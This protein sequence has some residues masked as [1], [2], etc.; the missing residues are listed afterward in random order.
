MGMFRR[1]GNLLRRGK[2]DGDIAAELEAHIELATER[3]MRQG[4]SS[5]DARRE[6]LLRFGNP[7]ST[8]ERVTAADTH[9]GLEG[10][11]RDIRYA[12]RQ[13]RHSPGFALTAIVTLAFGIGANVVVFGV[14]NSLILRPLNLPGSDRLYEVEHQEHGY[15]SQSYPDYLDFR[16]RNTAFSDLA[17]Y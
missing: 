16:A 1:M 11:A 3:M 14:L 5:A 2:V 8:R 9:L 7:T 15:L 12:I 4:L 6:A 13:L 10:M 17:T